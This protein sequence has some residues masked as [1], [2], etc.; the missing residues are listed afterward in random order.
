MSARDLVNAI[1]AGEAI[2]IEN[3]FNSAMA[4]KLSVGMDNMRE[5]IASNMF[6]EE[7]EQLDELSKTT[8]ASYIKRATRN[9][10]TTHAS[11][12]D[13][14]RRAD[15][16]EGDEA[17]ALRAD[18]RRDMEHSQRRQRGIV[19]AANKLTKEESELNLEDFSLEEIQDFMMSEDFEQLDEISKK[20]LVSYITKATLD[21]DRWKEAKADAGRRWARGAGGD[22][23]ENAKYAGKKVDKRQKGIDKVTD[24]LTKESIEAMVSAEFEQLDE[25]KKSTLASYIKKANSSTA[26]NAWRA[27]GQS[28]G[29]TKDERE[30]HQQTAAKTTM[31]RMAGVSKATDKLAKEETELNLED[32]SLEELQDFMMSEDFEQLNELS[33]GTLVSYIKKATSGLK[34]S[35][36]YAFDSGHAMAS[37]DKDKSDKDFNKA[38]KR[39]KGVERATDRLAKEEF[40][41]LD[42]LSKTT[43]G[44]Y[45]RKAN[46]SA[47]EHQRR[48]Q[49]DARHQDDMRAV[50]HF[51]SGKKEIDE[52]LRKA[53]A[54]AIDHLEKS[55]QKNIAKAD[56]RERGI[57]TA[58]KKLTKEESETN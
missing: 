17:R 21:K 7:V 20:T 3:A 28:L 48:A 27:A 2:G 30:K 29:L 49:S 46:V 37:G 16:R 9:A 19:Q 58:V 23:Y 15:D 34:G 11:A 33:K 43:L 54:N 14:S 18:A 5:H 36:R 24:K 22:E 40:E 1:I 47:T 56:K 12:R 39:V 25:L 38:V 35:A 8:L 57:E 44:K 55:K 51:W 13:T 32:F 41:Q 45:M 50:S 10:I 26:D 4:D 42:E 52:P 31:K 6:N 53:T